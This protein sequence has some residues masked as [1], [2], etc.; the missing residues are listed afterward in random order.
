MENRIFHDD[1]GSPI[2]IEIHLIIRKADGAPLAEQTAT[3]PW[4]A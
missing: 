3:V 4:L 1:S 2:Q